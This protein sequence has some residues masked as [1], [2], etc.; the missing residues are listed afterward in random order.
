LAAVS[1]VALLSAISL[2]A[3]TNTGMMKGSTDPITTGSTGGDGPNTGPSVKEMATAKQ[4]W[5]ADKTNVKKGLAYAGQ[6]MAFDQDR[7]ALQVVSTLVDSNPNDMMLASYYG[8]ILIQ[9]GQLAEGEKQLR[10]VI[11]AGKADWRD[12][13][14]LGTALDQQG[15]HDEARKMYETALAERPNEISVLNNLG[16]SYALQGDLKAAEATLRK[17]ADLP[18]G[19]SN[20]QVRQNLALVVG[21]QGNYEE[22]RTIASRD[23]PPDQAEANI[24]YLRQMMSQSNP[25]AQLKSGEQVQAAAAAQ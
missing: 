23:L 19:G 22:A 1:L 18:G 20:T 15:R 13:S 12:Y 9:S 16:M 10:R 14:A 21:L 4:A 11:S 5:E 17:A 7:E 3:C 8:K 2:S 6:L 25:W 24:A